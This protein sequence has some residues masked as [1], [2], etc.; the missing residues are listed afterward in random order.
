MVLILFT[1][2]VVIFFIGF[3]R[4]LVFI[5]R[6]VISWFENLTFSICLGG[7]VY[8]SCAPSVYSSLVFEFSVSCIDG[9]VFSGFDYS[10]IFIFIADLLIASGDVFFEPDLDLFYAVY[11]PVWS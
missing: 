2:L 4:D 3:L 7:D 1:H 10:Y 8:S 9:I 11:D 5:S 6:F